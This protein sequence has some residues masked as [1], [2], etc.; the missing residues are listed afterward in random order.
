MKKILLSF[1]VMLMALIMPYQADAQRFYLRVSDAVPEI[2]TGAL[3]VLQDPW[4]TD[5]HM[6]C[7]TGMVSTEIAEAVYTFEETG[8]VD[9]DNNKYYRLKQVNT[10]EYLEDPDLSNNKVS[11]TK[12]KARAF[13]FTA[14]PGI[15]YDSYED[16]TWRQADVRQKYYKQERKEF[17]NSFVFCN[18]NLDSPTLWFEVFPGANYGCMWTQYVN[19]NIWHLYKV[20]KCD[21]YNDLCNA[22]AYLCPNGI[23]GLYA[24]GNAPGQVAADLLNELNEAYAA[25]YKLQ[26]IEGQPDEVY[27]NAIDRLNAALVACQNGVVKLTAGYYVINNSPLSGRAQGHGTINACM[28]DTDGLMRWGGFDMD[29]KLKAED[30]IY[31]WQLIPAE[32]SN[33]GWYLM[34]Y[35]TKRYA[36]SV[37]KTNYFVPTSEKA[38]QIYDINHSKGDC[39]SLDMRDQNSTYPSLHANNSQDKAIVIWL[40]ISE[41]SWWN[42]IPVNETSLKEVDN[43]IEQGRINKATKALINDVKI[44]RG[45]GYTYTSSATLDGL[46]Q[47][48]NMGLVTKP[49]QYFSDTP[50]STEGKLSDN[51][52]L[53]NNQQTIFHSCWSSNEYAN[54]VHNLCADLTDE[55]VSIAIKYSRRNKGNDGCA[56]TVHVYTTNDTTSG[57]WVEQGYMTLSYPYAANDTYTEPGAANFTGIASIG[58][59]APYRFVRFDVEHTYSD[60]KA[61]SGIYFNFSE[62]RIYEAKYDPSKSLIEAVPDEILNKLEEALKTAETEYENGNVKKETYQA[63]EAAYDEFLKNYPDPQKIKSLLS[64]AEGQVEGAVEGPDLGFF[65]DGAIDAL[66]AVVE[67]VRGTIKDVM[68]VEE[69]QT[70]TN[71]LT[72]ALTAFNAK[73]NVPE[74]NKFFYIRCATTSTAEG[75]AMDNYLYATDNDESQVKYFLPEDMSSKLNYIWKSIKNEDGS[76]SFMN[77]ATGTYIGN[78]K[79]NNVLV[80]MSLNADSVSLRSAKVPGLFNFVCSNNVFYNS[81]PGTGNLVTWN[82]AN[83]TDNSAFAI[84]PFEE[85]S[86]VWDGSAVSFPISGKP[87]IISLPIELIGDA[88]GGNMYQVLGIKDN[89]LQL[90]PYSDTDVL[91][92]GTPFI[93]I[94]NEG[95]T[96][97]NFFTNGTQLSEM[98]YAT[99]GLIQNGLKATLQTTKDIIGGGILFEGG[100]ILAVEGDKSKANS[101][102]FDTMPSPTSEDG[103]ISM[104]FPESIQTAI[105]E[106][107]TNNKALKGI[108]S[109]TGIKVRND[110]NTNNLPKGI[111]IVNGNKVVVK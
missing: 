24:P 56:K 72:E 90:A 5:L 31:I 68:N 6:L 47:E 100:I 93:F 63:L 110:N 38:S 19:A 33:G 59:D 48:D 3:Y 35:G 27:L 23:E 84:E 97:N 73:L 60:A 43:D 10:G 4:T 40:P 66:K 25:A 99:E 88:D 21:A 104:A 12:T 7:G 92:P 85:A 106:I 46:Y 44:T 69:I 62:F 37:D 105:T 67:E 17:E 30:A 53:D 101:G 80:N 16:E 83:G 55:Y 52:L 103:E 41:A 71:K 64:E 1:V 79:S 54:K 70:A 39:F 76:Y 102:Y 42:F 78:P 65:A 29:G 87:E 57:N 9:P 61:Q 81:Q 75:S 91:A 74:G 28:K 22:I 86:N 96:S 107:I 36:G 95:A 18:K 82:S 94:P 45:R 8:E 32:E 15:G 49:E 50:E 20:E 109:L 11:M 108:Y 51:G 58:F 98:E 34:N 13:V 14:L 2:E 26:N 89:L 77:C 111:Y